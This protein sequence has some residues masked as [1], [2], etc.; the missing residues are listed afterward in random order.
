MMSPVKHGTEKY[1]LTEV[2]IQCSIG[3]QKT[4]FFACCAGCP[5][6]SQWTHMRNS[7]TEVAAAL[8]RTNYRKDLPN[9]F[10]LTDNLKFTLSIQI[11]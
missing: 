1:Q 7:P 5:H 2:N 10:I 6:G 11:V 9:P 4:P 8:V 3:K